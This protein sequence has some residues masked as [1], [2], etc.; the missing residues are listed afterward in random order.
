MHYLDSSY[1]QIKPVGFFH[2]IRSIAW[3]QYQIWNQT[4]LDYRRDD[5]KTEKQDEESNDIEEE[6][7]G[8]SVKN[9]V[10]FPQET[11]KGSW[12]ED[13]SLSDHARLTVVFTPIRISY[14]RKIS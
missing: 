12:P 9:A 1:R 5:N 4:G 7:I 14:S 8:F 11:E 10:L 13:Y 6:T 2:L 3:L